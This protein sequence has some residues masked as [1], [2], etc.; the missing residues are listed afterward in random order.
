MSNYSWCA[1]ILFCALAAAPARAADAD[2]WQQRIDTC[3]VQLTRGTPADRDAAE[4]GLCL[5][6]P[7]A[8]TELDA[9]RKRPG[10][11]PMV[12]LLIQRIVDRERKRNVARAR[13]KKARIEEA[14]WNS[15]TALAA[16]EKTGH[17]SPKWDSAAKEGIRR[18]AAPPEPIPHE[19]ERKPLEEAIAAGCDD[20]LILYFHA[21]M[22]EKWAPEDTP[23]I[24]HF[25][26]SAMDGMEHDN[27][28]P[29]RMASAAADCFR[30]KVK[31][32]SAH[33][34]RAGIA[35]GP[36]V[37]AELQ[38]A[39]GLSRGVW[40][41]VLQEKNIPSGL[42]LDLGELILRDLKAKRGDRTPDF[43]LMYNLLQKSMPNSIAPL[44]FK[45][46]FYVDF[47]WDARGHDVANTVTPARWKQ[48]HERLA[49]A[50]ESL[51]RA[52]KIVPNDPR[53]PTQMLIVVKGE[54]K[55][56]IQ[57][58]KWF[59]RALDADPDNVDAC[60]SKLEYL[61]PQWYGSV[62][63]MQ[64]FGQE[65]R[66]DGN[67]YGR[68]PLELVTMYDKLSRNK[69]DPAATFRQPEVWHAVQSV[70]EPYLSAEPDDEFRRSRYTWYA[71]RAEQWDVAK[72][73]FQLL[74]DKAVAMQ[75][76]GPQVLAKMR[77]D[78][79]Q[80]GK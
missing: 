4:V 9:A 57:M 52:W 66:D 44:V 14:T 18:F 78:A 49:I 3:I 30:Y 77:E 39:I 67:W 10:P 41:L 22:L 65:L 11:S 56:R 80:K 70:Y 36:A 58:E 19:S 5:I 47:A 20:P 62:Q 45:G 31:V 42:V 27:Y 59:K 69:P 34:P 8:T 32:E 24:L 26:E 40:P 72:T 61:L 60:D 55:P 46:E 51:T 23:D 73:Q 13:I 33:M 79:A 38:R 64:K 76:R 15:D 54:E 16:Y 50:D 71:G 17:K 48:F 74:G 63:D 21:K 37:T 25:Y 29:Y 68:L 28:P 53:A 7:E 75:F 12:A 1:L 43:A 6:A 35:F 2:V